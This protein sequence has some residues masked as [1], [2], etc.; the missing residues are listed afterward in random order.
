MGIYKISLWASKNPWKTRILL[1]SIRNVLLLNALILGALLFLM[2]VNIPSAL[3]WLMG[4][5]GG[6][7]FVVYPSKHSFL[8]FLPN[9]F[10][11]RKICDLAL[12][13]ATILM[14]T[15]CSNGFLQKDQ[16]AYPN[17]DEVSASFVVHKP[18][19]K[20]NNLSFKLSDLFLVKEYRKLKKRY[21]SEFRALKKELKSVDGDTRNTGVMVL[22]IIL[23]VLVAFILGTLGLALSCS[24][25]CSGSD[26]LG[27]A[28][29]IIA[30]VGVP[31]ALFFVIRK[32]VRH[33]RIK[34]E[35]I[36]R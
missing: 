1:F 2:D 9:T 4:I 20:D 27:V 29:F 31:I 26:F 34:K 23:S 21:K 11:N 35:L 15:F 17:S 33:F 3:V 14:V 13:V 10:R 12:S 18:S 36:Y 16:I 19:L 5:L 32:I 22:L 25:L 24:L 8:S 30:I 7:V 6:L 28:V